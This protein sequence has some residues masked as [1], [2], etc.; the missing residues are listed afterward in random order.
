MGIIYFTLIK[1]KTDFVEDIKEKCNFNEDYDGCYTDSAVEIAIQNKDISI[2][3]NGKLLFLNDFNGIRCFSKYMQSY[4]SLE[5]C[6]KV[7]INRYWCLTE[8]AKIKKDYSICLKVLDNPY[9]E[10][11]ELGKDWC[12]EKFT[13]EG[14]S[15]CQKMGKNS[16]KTSCVMYNAINKSNVNICKQFIE[17][18]DQNTTF[19]D[20]QVCKLEVAIKTN[21]KSIC[22]SI[23]INFTKT[24]CENE[25]K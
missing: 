17:R 20:I 1:P 14:I 10:S 8:L 13:K 12:L 9:S 22:D 3:E 18:E 5:E 19:R 6:E 4:P 21:N 16:Y 15:I 24:L 11:P 7:K 2:C 23:E 25:F